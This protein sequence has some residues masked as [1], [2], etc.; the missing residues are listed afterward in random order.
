MN[1]R[2]TNIQ[3]FSTYDGPGI[4]TTIFTKGCS[5][6]CPWCANPENIKYEIEE[7]CDMDGCKTRYGIDIPVE[8]VFKICMKDE[9]F[10]SNSGGVTFSGGEVLLQSRSVE[11]LLQLFKAN[12]IGCGIETSL[13]AS[14]KNLERV[15]DY[16]DFVFVDMKLLDDNGVHSI[17]NGNLNVYLNNLDY[18]FQNYNRDHIII[19]IPL[20]P[21]I[22]ETE[23]NLK[24]CC[25]LLEKYHPSKCEIFSVHNL[26]RSKYRKMNAD[27]TVFDTVGKER[28]I[29]IADMLKKTDVFVEINE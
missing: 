22:T 12:H 13:Y 29:E 14:R 25:Y 27:Y 26:A 11:K 6:R 10:Y 15:L 2:I 28:L 3:R 9:M 16:L 23:D 4:R 17:L 18:L 1:I 7:F 20:I 8:E 21:G 5:L 24:K 19:R